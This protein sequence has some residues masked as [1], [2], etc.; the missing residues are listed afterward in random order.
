MVL[1]LKVDEVLRFDDLLP[2]ELEYARAPVRV[3]SAKLA[4][5]LFRKFDG[6]SANGIKGAVGDLFGWAMEQ[7]AEFIE[8]R[9]AGT[10]QWPRVWLAEGGWRYLCDRA[11]VVDWRDPK[12]RGDEDAQKF[13]A[14]LSQSRHMQEV[15]A[16][17]EAL[18]REPWLD[19]EGAVLRG[20]VTTAEGWQFN[21]GVLAADAQPAAW[22]WRNAQYVKD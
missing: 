2:D 11:E 8:V 13:D 9:L 22:P 4:Q 19:D 21:L 15:R 3:Q 17:R 12:R 16:M 5:T 7:Q 14:M 18:D 6:M 20:D 1:P 10:K